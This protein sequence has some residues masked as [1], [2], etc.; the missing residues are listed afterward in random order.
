MLDALKTFYQRFAARRVFAHWAANYET[1][2][3]A[4]RYSAA[5]AVQTALL[6]HLTPDSRILDIGIGTG[7]IWD[8]IDMP[9][10]AEIGGIDIC[11]DMLAQASS[12]PDI[13]ALFLC[14]AGREE[15]P[16]EDAYLNMVVSA[17]L[18]EYL[19]ESMARHVFDE[20]RRTLKSGGLLIAT[21][22]PAERNET[23][24]WKGKS[25]AIFSCLY[26]PVWMEAQDGFQLLEHSPPFTGSIF[27]DGS[28]YDYRL[29]VL[30]RD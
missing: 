7:M 14:D 16:C 15:W 30:K 24:F 8:G 18:F 19:T 25:G 2:V 26:S 29:I 1:D 9:E 22:I 4:N 3:Q 13:G 20:A 21:Y 10:T 27:A 6:P 17:G 11:E 23:R 5:K 12:H 28:S